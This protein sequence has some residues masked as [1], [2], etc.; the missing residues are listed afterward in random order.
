MICRVLLFCATL[1]FAGPVLAQPVSLARC[2]DLMATAIAADAIGLPSGGA[3]VMVAR[4]LPAAAPLAPRRDPDGEFAQ[5]VPAHCNI[6][7]EI[8]PHDPA[9]PP[10]TFNLNLPFAWNGRALQSGGGGLGGALIT[11]PEQKASARFD[12]VPTHL[13]YPIALGYATFGSDGGH[14]GS[15]VA[16]MRSDEAMRNWGRDSMKKTRDVALA[17]IALAYGRP[18]QRV[19]FSGESAGGREA[20]MMAQHFPADYD[21]IVAVSPV[22]SWNAIHLADNVIRTRLVSGW[23][24][25]AAIRLLAEQTRAQCD[26]E[27]GLR[28]GIIARYL[29]CR[30]DAGALRCPG[31][32]AGEG[33][34]SDAQIAAVGAIRE[35][36]SM[37]VPLAHGITRY[38]GY[39]VTGDEDNGRYQYG[40]YTVGTAR[41][42]HPL[43]PGRGFEPGRGAILNFAAIWIRHA[44][45]GDPAADPLHFDPRPHGPRIQY[46]STIFDATDPDLSRFRQRGGRLI[47]LHPTADNAVGTP[48]IAEY[49]RSVVARLGEAETDTFLRL[50]IAHGGGHNV[51][52]VAQLDT[53]S[54]LEAWLDGTPPPDAPP[55]FEVDPES[56]Q[57]LRSM[58]V[59]RYPAYARY[60]GSGD[61]RRAESFVC[62]ARPDPLGFRPG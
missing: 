41:P 21:G 30:N 25:A 40:F 56:Q 26:A 15:D 57:V 22:L 39:G 14:Q 2:E 53:L 32:G 10:I 60:P 3:R 46:L 47:I 50:Y 18:A 24:D 48:M 20:L 42:S 29:E 62:T 51:T 27:D 31:G 44:I 35:P 5:G 13:P 17:L 19:L 23:L 59:C 8:A 12:P 61:P 36:W 55:A 37:A 45:L 34:L 9:A 49:W 16:F 58:P 6:Q 54:M 4:R 33:C 7:G 52:G 38:P 43:P 1:A 11:A 28:D